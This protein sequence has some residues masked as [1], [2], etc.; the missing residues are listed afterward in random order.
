MALQVMDRVR[1]QGTRQPAACLA[2][3]HQDD[4]VIV[5]AAGLHHRR[6]NA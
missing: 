4:F 2:A 1:M 6:V 5:M 3:G